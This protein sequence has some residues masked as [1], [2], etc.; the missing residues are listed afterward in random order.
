MVGFVGSPLE[1]SCHHHRDGGF[2]HHH[3]RAPPIR[4]FGSVGFQY[5]FV[6]C[7]GFL[8]GGY[9]VVWLDL[10]FNAHILWIAGG[11]CSDLWFNGQI[12]RWWLSFSSLPDLVFGVVG[13]GLMV[14][15]HLGWRT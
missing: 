10:W 12:F 5:G 15:A 6:S 7:F 2:L 3:G 14:Y 8:L 9:G 4:V 13:G 1:A 11:L